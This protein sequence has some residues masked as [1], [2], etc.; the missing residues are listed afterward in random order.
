MIALH[1]HNP[2][3][4]GVVIMTCDQPFVSELLVRRIVDRFNAFACKIVACDYAD[5][6]GV[7]AA[8]HRDLFP[9]L[10]NLF[11]DKGAK[12]LIEIYATETKIVDFPDGA[13]DIDTAQEYSQLLQAEPHAESTIH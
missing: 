3:L 7:P 6:V 2:R 10:T 9:E 12:T 5:T 8:F 1:Q 13:I 4:D 11:G